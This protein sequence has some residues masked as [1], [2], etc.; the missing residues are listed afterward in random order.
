MSKAQAENDMMKRW[1]YLQQA[2]KVAM[3]DVAYI[4]VFEKGNAVLVNPEV[5]GLVD[6]AVGVPYTFNYVEK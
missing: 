6:K 2:E 5:K 1:T 3:D 4:P